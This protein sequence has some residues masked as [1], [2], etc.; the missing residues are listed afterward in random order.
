MGGQQYQM[1]KKYCLKNEGHKCIFFG[2]ADSSFRTPEGIW[3]DPGS[4]DQITPIR[5]QTYLK[6]ESLKDVVELLFTQNPGME[7]F[8]ISKISDYLKK[9]CQY[10]EQYVQGKGLDYELQCPTTSQQ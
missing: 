8:V 3:V 1:G 6:H 2:N 5:D 7:D 4:A 10:K 9:G